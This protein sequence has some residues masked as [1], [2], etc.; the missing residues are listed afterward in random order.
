[1]KKVIILVLAILS[2]PV[3]GADIVYDNPNYQLLL[4]ANAPNDATC[5]P[6]DLVGGDDSDSVLNM[7][8]AATDFC[9]DLGHSGLESYVVDPDTDNG[10]TD[11]DPDV[12]E[13]STNGLGGLWRF[14][15]TGV[16]AFSQIICSD[17]SGC[18]D[19]DSI[20]YD[21][22][23]LI[24]DG[25]CQQCSG[26]NPQ[27]CSQNA[28][29]QFGQ[30]DGT[31]CQPNQLGCTDPNAENY[32]TNANTGQ[33]SLYCEYCAPNDDPL[34]CSNQ[35]DC[36]NLGGF[37][38]DTVLFECVDPSGSGGGGGNNNGGEVTVQWPDQ[39][40]YLPVTQPLQ[41]GYHNFLNV[42]CT[43]YNSSGLCEKQ[44]YDLNEEFLSFMLSSATKFG[45]YFFFFG[46]VV[47]LFMVGVKKFTKLFT[48]RH[49]E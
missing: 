27:G 40:N 49:D 34:N 48:D 12:C 36:E 10:G 25:T 43:Q 18:T 37:I 24:D 1:M 29:S 3:Y 38:W 19:P 5:I 41:P 17:P 13:S 21:P 23:A 35:S 28:C 44:R 45:T 30:W 26:S 14:D 2:T 16:Y 6:S 11:L 8:N 33:E 22:N 42:S 39:T 9:T 32:N 20:N 4:D 7:G 47:W 31:Q 46:L 15:T